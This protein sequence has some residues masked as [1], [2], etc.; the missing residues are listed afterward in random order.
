MGESS[1]SRT[2]VKSRF[3]PNRGGDCRFLT[4][5]SSV[6]VD[7]NNKRKHHPMPTKHG[8][9]PDD[10]LPLF[11]SER[12]DEP[13][14][15]GIGIAWD[16]A[17]I[18]SRILKTSILVVTATAIVFAILS[19]GNPV[20]F[21]ANVRASL[22]DISALRPGTDQSTPTIQLIAG[23]QDL[24]PTA[25]DEPP[26]SPGAN[27]ESA[28]PLDDK[29]ALRPPTSGSPTATDAPTRNETA[30]AFEPA[31]QS[32]TESRQPSADADALFKQFQAWTAERAMKKH[33][34]VRP[35]QNAEAEI[36]P[37]L[38]PRAKIRREQ[39]AR[40]Q[41]PPVQDARAQD[42]SVQNAEAPSFLQSLG[43]RN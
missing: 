23:T 17:V 36:R 20:A 1:G 43:L 40:V 4:L 13:E 6:L 18:S 29:T 10:P 26:V 19:V 24:P 7:K 37:E 34:R 22:V 12:A 35:V 31:D 32:Q 5:D 15:V 42:Q 11:L 9:A 30:A 21:F 8:F 38:H 39:N 2:L 16:R 14:Q 3:L 25:R 33:R 27:P 41:V 28:P